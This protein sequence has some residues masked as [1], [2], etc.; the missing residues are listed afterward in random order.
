MPLSHH[1][2]HSLRKFTDEEAFMATAF[3]QRSPWGGGFGKSIVPELCDELPPINA[4][5]GRD[6]VGWRAVFSSTVEEC[7]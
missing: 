4:K 7:A 2:A 3:L 1:N 5:G 6:A